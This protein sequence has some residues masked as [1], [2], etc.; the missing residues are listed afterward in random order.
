MMHQKDSK[1]ILEKIMRKHKFKGVSVI[2]I[3]VVDTSLSY[4]IKI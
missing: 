1:K 4:L 3:E 2:P